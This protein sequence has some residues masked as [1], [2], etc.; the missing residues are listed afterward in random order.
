MQIF[1]TCSADQ[2]D[3]LICISR[4]PVAWIQIAALIG[5]GIMIV[6]D[7][8][9]KTR[10]RHYRGGNDFPSS[11]LL[12][13]WHGIFPGAGA[14]C[15]ISLSL[16]D[17]ISVYLCRGRCGGCNDRPLPRRPPIARWIPAIANTGIAI[18]GL[19]IF[20]N[21][22]SVRQPRMA[23]EAILGASSIAHT[24]VHK[25]DIHRYLEERIA[26]A[27]GKSL[28]DMLLSISARMTASCVSAIRSRTAP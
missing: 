24:P 10:P 7:K 12:F 11:L 22:I 14:H 28:G 17:S 21:V 3:F 4:T 26:L 9:K 13:D 8:R 2:G 5:G 18:V 27:A 16:L 25:G 6:F 20:T 19:V 15:G 1:S 23:G